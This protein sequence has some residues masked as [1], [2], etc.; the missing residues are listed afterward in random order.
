MNAIFS[1][2]STSATPVEARMVIAFL[3]PLGREGDRR[4][5]ERETRAVGE[6]H[7]LD[8][9]PV[10]LRPVRRAEVDEPVCRALLHDLCVAARHVGVVDLHVDVPRAADDG[11]LRL[12][13]APLAAP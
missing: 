2:R 11:A 6:P 7:A 10:H 3:F 8:A 5:T 12:E 4:L 13:D 9:P 1:A